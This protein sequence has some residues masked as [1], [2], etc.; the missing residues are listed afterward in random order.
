[1]APFSWPITQMLSP[2]KRPNPPIS[3][4]SSPNLRSPAS[5][6][7]SDDQ[8]VDE[9]GQ[10]RPLRMTRYQGFL[11]RR[12]VGVEIVQRLRRLV[13]DPRD[14]LADVAAGSRQHAQ[15]ID[16][17]VEFGDGFFEIKVTAHLIRH[18]INIGAN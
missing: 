9:I 18:Q 13:L 8:R 11:P 7:N 3:A 17:G 15:F 5:G 6:V 1:M 4:S 16:L 2:R 14:F 12:Q 10:M